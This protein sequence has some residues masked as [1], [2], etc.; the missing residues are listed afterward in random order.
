[1]NVQEHN[2]YEF[3]CTHSLQN[4]I[5]FG[6]LIENMMNSQNV[7]EMNTCMKESFEIMLNLCRNEHAYEN[8]HEINLKLHDM[9]MHA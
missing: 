7:S 8:S 4:M 2:M 5:K 1:M 3:S 9:D 6:K